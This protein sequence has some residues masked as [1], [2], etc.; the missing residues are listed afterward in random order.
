MKKLLLTSLITF[1]F[2]QNVFAQGET[3]IIVNTPEM[4]DYM[5]KNYCLHFNSSY[6]QIGTIVDFEGNLRICE[7]NH[8]GT[9]VWGFKAK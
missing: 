6:L 1:L 2:N 3:K 7:I 9:A 5:N 4:A 8:K